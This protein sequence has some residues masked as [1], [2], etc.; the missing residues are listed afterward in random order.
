LLDPPT[1]SPSTPKSPVSVRWT[2]R[3]ATNVFLELMPPIN[4]TPLF[5]VSDEVPTTGTA[6]FTFD[7]S[8]PVEDLYGR[9]VGSTAPLADGVLAIG[10]NESAGKISPTTI[11]I[12]IP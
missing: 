7:C 6:V 3:Y 11:K 1:C 8:K 5:L 10:N 4:A 2:S 9:A 12:K